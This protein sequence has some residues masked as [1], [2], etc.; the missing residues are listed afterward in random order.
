MRIST[1]ELDYDE[2]D[3]TTDHFT[4]K[5]WWSNVNDNGKCGY[6]LIGG[7]CNRGHKGSHKCYDKRNWKNYRN[8]QYKTVTIQ[9]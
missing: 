7:G 9:Q 3:Y 4:W 8:T 6:C 5:V 2:Y 1:L